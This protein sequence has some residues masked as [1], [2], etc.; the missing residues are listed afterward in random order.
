MVGMCQMA[1]ET[2][3]GVFNSDSEGSKREINLK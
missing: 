2:G 1:E 3:S